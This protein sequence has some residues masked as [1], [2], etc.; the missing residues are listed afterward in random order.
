MRM[1]WKYSIVRLGAILAGIG[2][3][4]AAFGIVLWEVH[5]T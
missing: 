2:S 5:A 1:S 3:T 4:L